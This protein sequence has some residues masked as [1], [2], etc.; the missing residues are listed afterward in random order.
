MH[1]EDGGMVYKYDLPVV[2]T[3][4]EFHNKLVKVDENMEMQTQVQ[5]MFDIL[6][7]NKDT[8]YESFMIKFS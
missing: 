6:D 4:I 5:K 3:P 7:C 1:G 2:N 8:A